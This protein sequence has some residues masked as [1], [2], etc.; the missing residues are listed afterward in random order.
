MIRF[1]PDIT[2]A[3]AAWAAA[4]GGMMFLTDL[5]GG[6]VIVRRAD[7]AA[8]RGISAS[9]REQHGTLNIFPIPRRRLQIIGVR[10][11]DPKELEDA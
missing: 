5:R 9:S 2:L 10:H 7:V 3:E 11:P 8:L 1:H 6:A 4:A